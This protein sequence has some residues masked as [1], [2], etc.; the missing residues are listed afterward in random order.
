MPFPT[1][2]PLD[3]DLLCGHC[4]HNLR[5]VPS[6]RCP[7][8]GTPFDR[9]RILLPTVPWEQ[10]RLRGR[11]RSYWRTVGVVTFRPGRLAALA[12]HDI[13]LSAAKVFRRWTASLL[14]LTLLAVLLAWRFYPAFFIAPYNWN[15]PEPI[16]FL[17]DLPRPSRS[18]LNTWF[19]ATAIVTLL[20]S[21]IAITGVAAYLFHPPRL[22][23]ARQRH[24]IALSYYATA[25]L[26][27]LAPLAALAAGSL[28]WLRAIFNGFGWL[29][30]IVA[31]L[32]DSTIVF[33]LLSPLAWWWVT[34]R[35]LF[36][37]TGSRRRS[38]IAAIVL[39]ALWLLLPAITFVALEVLVNYTGFF[40]VT[41]HW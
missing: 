17:P 11:L 3:A 22:P 33:C 14:F 13:T 38:S 29:P 20:L 4:F 9:S 24:G 15:A 16:V 34:I 5:G 32:Y 31:S 27:W 21:V 18:V 26:A 39:P 7:E 28:F 25:P 8:C 19:F 23:M 2:V 1:P 37:A 10:R 36:A 41:F 30:V 40:C 6:N 12:E 35:L